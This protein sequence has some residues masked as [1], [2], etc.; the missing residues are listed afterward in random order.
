M[1]SVNSLGCLL[2][3]K[4]INSLEEIYLFSLPIRD[5][6]STGFRLGAHLKDEVLRTMR[7]GKLR[8]PV[9]KVEDFRHYQALYWLHLSPVD[10]LTGPRK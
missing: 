7:T 1:I 9:F 4:T 5:S 8:M 6:E 2:K 10:L 3:D